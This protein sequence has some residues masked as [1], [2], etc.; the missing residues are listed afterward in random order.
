MP[1]QAQPES[2]LT[3]SDEYS[4]GI[5]SLDDQHK[6]LVSV[7]GRL[8]EALARGLASEEL[9]ALIE[10]L[11]TYARYHF[12]WEEQLLESHG[13]EELSAHRDE[14]ARLTA[15]V[16]AFQEKAVGGRLF[17]GTPVLRF[18]RNWLIEHIQGTDS[19]YGTF[20]AQRGVR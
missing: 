5:P 15:Q 3:W 18:L 7:I 9:P 8:Q 16:L 19:H 13:F 12:A 17:L 10:M 14:H 20:L 2:V 11:V 6:V 1:S 4:V